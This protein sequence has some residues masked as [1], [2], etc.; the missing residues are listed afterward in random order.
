[1]KPLASARS[2]RWNQASQTDRR[3]FSL[4]D[5]QQEIYAT[6]QFRNTSGSL[7]TGRTSEG[8][9]TFKRVGFFKPRI[10]VRPVSLKTPVAFFQRARLHFGGGLVLRW[11]PT[12]GPEKERRFE[13]LEGRTVVRL[14]PEFADR[15]RE[16]KVEIKAFSTPG[17]ELSIA[18]L[19]S[20]YIVLLLQR[21]KE[22]EVL[23]TG[24][25]MMMMSS[26]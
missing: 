12:K 2:L 24:S 6:L 11:N 25:M 5:P 7:G 22:V 8:E 14:Q 26:S 20:W 13:D 16:A 4:C 1:M 17:A 23:D 10:S 3:T 19:M 18:V 21:Q 15:T 9:W